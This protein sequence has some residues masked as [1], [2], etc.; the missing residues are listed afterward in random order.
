ML[1]QVIDQTNVYEWKFVKENENKI[2]I[3]NTVKKT[4]NRFDKFIKE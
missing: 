1:G 4:T 2:D 3:N